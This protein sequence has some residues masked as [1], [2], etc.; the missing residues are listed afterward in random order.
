MRGSLVCSAAPVGTRG[1]DEVWYRRA[2]E[3]AAATAS[4]ESAQSAHWVVSVPLV[5][6]P[7]SDVYSEYNAAYDQD[8]P[9]AARR[10]GLADDWS[11]YPRP[12]LTLSVS[13]V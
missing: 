2:V 4:G 8:D 1:P 10:A 11:G 7:G 12:N 9:W 3:S 5:D 6:E 13:G